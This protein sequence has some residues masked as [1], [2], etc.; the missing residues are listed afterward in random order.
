MTR[1]T[2]SDLEFPAIGDEAEAAPEETK[3]TEINRK[4]RATE[5]RDAV[6]RK[7]TWVPVGMLP[8]PEPMPGWRF[9]YVRTSMVGTSDPMNTN[10]RFREGWVPVTVEEQPQL[11]HVVDREVHGKGN[12]IIGGLML[13]KMPIE[14][15]E[16]RDE[17]IDRTSR[18]QLQTV[19]SALMRESDPRMPI[20]TPDRSTETTYGRKK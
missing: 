12:I 18:E 2:S 9:R 8:D 14:M 16:A 7:A 5:S 11:E 4:P 17:Y 15:A 1:R 19:D 3:G 10:L 6:K 20:L 13:C